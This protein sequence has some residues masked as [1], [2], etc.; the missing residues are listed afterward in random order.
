MKKLT[1]C[2]ELKNILFICLEMLYD[3]SYTIEEL[4]IRPA[5]PF[6]QRHLKIKKDEYTCLDVYIDDS[7]YPSFQVRTVKNP[8][9][10]PIKSK[11]G[12]Q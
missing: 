8:D 7:D 1:T 4:P 12:K 6:P 3:G 10:I 11:G 5:Q 2:Q 9:Y